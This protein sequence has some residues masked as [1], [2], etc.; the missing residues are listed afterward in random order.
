MSPLHDDTYFSQAERRKCLC[1]GQHSRRVKIGNLQAS[2]SRAESLNDNPLSSLAGWR[3]DLCFGRCSRGV[4]AEQSSDS[5]RREWG[6]RAGNF[7][8]TRKVS[9][10]VSAIHSCAWDW[11][12]GLSRSDVWWRLRAAVD[13]MCVGD[14]EHQRCPRVRSDAMGWKRDQIIDIIDIL[15]NI[16][17]HIYINI[18]IDI[19]KCEYQYWHWYL[20]LRSG[21]KGWKRLVT[22][23]GIDFCVLLAILFGRER[24]VVDLLCCDNLHGS[25]IH[26]CTEGHRGAQGFDRHSTGTQHSRQILQIFSKYSIFGV[27]IESLCPSISICRK[28]IYQIGI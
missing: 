12:R 28:G 20:K 16:E 18:D 15:S 14:W 6:Y 22:R 26:Q 13:L 19:W 7:T 25:K 8:R 10:S 11:K 4:G 2:V 24:C 9:I 1:Y 5:H 3:K 17:T 27:T 23:Q 21:A